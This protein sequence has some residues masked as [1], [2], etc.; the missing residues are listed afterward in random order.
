MNGPFLLSPTAFDPNP[1]E[2]AYN[3]IQKLIA[4]CNDSLLSSVVAEAV[5]TMEE[6][7]TKFPPESVSV[8]FNGGKDCVVMLHIVHAV[9]QKL[10]PEKKMK[11][12]YVSEERTFSEVDTFMATT[13]ETYK[14]DT[15]TY[16]QPMKVN[17]GWFRIDLVNVQVNRV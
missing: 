4:D 6:C 11:S 7:F 3:K 5:Q 15:K 2:D 8:C 12:F 10:F 9:H 14:L 13:I 17:I 1:T 16:Q